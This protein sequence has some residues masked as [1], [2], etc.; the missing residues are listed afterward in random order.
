[1]DEAL[2]RHGFGEEYYERIYESQIERI[3]DEMFG[4][5]M[6]DHDDYDKVWEATAEEIRGGIVAA[7]Q[8]NE[9]F[10]EEFLF[11]MTDSF[12]TMSED[13]PENV[14]A[15]RDLGGTACRV[16][17]D[18]E[19]AKFFTEFLSEE[20]G[21]KDLDLEW[22]VPFV[23]ETG[24]K[25]EQ[26]VERHPVLGESLSEESIEASSAREEIVFISVMGGSSTY[27]PS[28]ESWDYLDFYIRDF[29]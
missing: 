21:E 18:A 27:C 11:A 23:E 20:K 29:W 2:E 28:T 4:D 26:A 12:F 25:L 17:P 19:R 3:G 22:L 15:F 9:S 16:V 14:A 7:V 5:E 10:R 24:G 6:F 1:M 13:L 8:E